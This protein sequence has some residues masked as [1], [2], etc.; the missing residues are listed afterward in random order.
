MAK[1]EI[2]IDDITT[3]VDQLW[4][5]TKG[6]TKDDKHKDQQKEPIRKSG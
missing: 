2:N 6:E 3:T 4:E 5:Q 1:I